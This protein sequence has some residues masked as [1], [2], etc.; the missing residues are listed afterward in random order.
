MSKGWRREDP[1]C[2]PDSVGCPR[3]L[4][5]LSEDAK[6]RS[7]WQWESGHWSKPGRFYDAHTHREQEGHLVLSVRL[8][9]ASSGRLADAPFSLHRVP[10]Y[11]G[12]L[13]ESFHVQFP[14]D[15]PSELR[16]AYVAHYLPGVMAPDPM[17]RWLALY[18]LSKRSCALGRWEDYTR[19]GLRGIS[20]ELDGHYR[21]FKKW[22]KA[23]QD[24]KHRELAEK[25]L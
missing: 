25:H 9:R 13:P 6:W 11:P 19:L 18:N 3:D 1:D 22:E 14:S 12:G 24:R 17:T 21:T 23:E 7:L 4:S 2:N 8:V 15:L 20:K 5:W 16:A 10:W